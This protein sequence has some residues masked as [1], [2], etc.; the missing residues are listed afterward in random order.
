MI[1]AFCGCALRSLNDARTLS[2]SQANRGR[3][4]EIAGGRSDKVVVC[5]DIDACNSRVAAAERR[6]VAGE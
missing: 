3:V 5:R 1:C 2:V 6:R 4:R